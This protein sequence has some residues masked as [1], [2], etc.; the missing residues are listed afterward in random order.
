M[1]GVS[2]ALRKRSSW[3]V[4][5]ERIERIR[6]SGRLW[7]WGLDSARSTRGDPVR[8]GEEFRGA[9]C[10]VGHPPISRRASH[11]EPLPGMPHPPGEAASKEGDAFLARLRMRGVLLLMEDGPC[12]RRVPGMRHPFGHKLRS[13]PICQTG[14]QECRLLAPALDQAQ[15]LSIVCEINDRVLRFAT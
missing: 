1:P 15:P 2:R 13:A 9:S 6:V 3:H 5:G 8:R 14:K 11:H 12:S 4:S 10:G 7:S